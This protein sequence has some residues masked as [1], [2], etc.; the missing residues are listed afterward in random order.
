MFQGLREIF[1]QYLYTP[2]V[3]TCAYESM[4]DHN[5]TFTRLLQLLRDKTVNVVSAFCLSSHN[6]LRLRCETSTLVSWKTVIATAP[7]SVI[8]CP[9][10]LTIRFYKTYSPRALAINH[11]MFMNN[12]FNNAASHSHLT[13]V[14]LQPITDFSNAEKKQCY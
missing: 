13:H 6:A 5:V 11:V 14:N 9:Y 2:R 12:A 8:N 4:N 7:C 10:H 3:Q 1:N